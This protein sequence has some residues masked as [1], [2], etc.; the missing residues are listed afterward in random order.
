MRRLHPDVQHALAAEYVLGTLRGRA[1]ARFEALARADIAL[2]T[3]VKEWEAFLTPLALKLKPVEPPESVWRAIEARIGGRTAAAAAPSFW[4]SLGFWRTVG[5]GF[6]GL[7]VTLLAMT[8]TLAPQKAT[9]PAGAQMVAV[10]TS[11]GEDK[12]P[13]MV[14]EK[15]AGLVR[16]KMVKSWALEP[17]QDLELWVVPKDGPARSL[18]VVSNE[19][20]TDVKLPNLDKMVADGTAFAISREPKGGSPTGTATGP[21][22]CVGPIARTQRV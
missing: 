12:A 20:N 16:V 13:R 1:R 18:G 8:F 15:H 14:V 10:L 19:G 21:V 9:E 22:L 11:T 4:N 2:G 17:S 6:A 3:I 5:A 7:A